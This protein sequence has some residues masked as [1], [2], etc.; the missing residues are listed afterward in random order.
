MDRV[1]SLLA[2]LVGLIALGG[3]ILVHTNADT[4]RREMAT[5]IAALKTSIS[6]LGGPAP[7]STTTAAIPQL[8][9]ITAEKQASMPSA[10]VS[11]PSAEPASSAEAAASSSSAA[12]SEALDTV[13]AMQDLQARIASLEAQ[14]KEQAAELDA[15][16]AQLAAASSASAPTQVATADPVTPPA[17]SASVPGGSSSQPPTPAAVVANGPTKDCIPLGTRFM[18][19]GGDSFPICKTKL[20]L[21]VAAV[22]DGLATITGAGDVAAGATVPYDKGCTLAVFSADNSGYAEMRVTCQ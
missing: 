16:R 20:V 22:T 6:L 14:T 12:S 4:Q 9:P 13:K 15:A 7:A 2:A 18:G 17:P 11:I 10:A 21:K 3:A 8:T 1:I 19:Q 5:Q